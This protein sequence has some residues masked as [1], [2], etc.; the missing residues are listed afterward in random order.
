MGRVT[1]RAVM[2]TTKR[3]Y[4][5]YLGHI[6]RF[7]NKYRL[8][9]SVLLGQVYGNREERKGYRGGHGAQELPPHCSVV[10]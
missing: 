9:I 5:E 8:L 6:R 4:I 3:R 10:N 1:T 7:E 2:D